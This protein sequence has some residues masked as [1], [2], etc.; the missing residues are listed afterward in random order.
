MTDP[1]VRLIVLPRLY[2]VELS[3]AVSLPFKAV[4]PDRIENT[5]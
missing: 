4:L 3:I 1:H 2:A 5:F